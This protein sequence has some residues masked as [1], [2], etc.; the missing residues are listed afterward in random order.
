VSIPLPW[1]E[2]TAAWLQRAAPAIALTVHNAACL[3][4][5]EG[6][7]V[8]GN[9]GRALLTELLQALDAALGR[10]SWEGVTHPAL[11]A[12]T[13]GSDARAIGGA[14]LP[15]YAAYAPDSDLFLKIAS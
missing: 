2:A 3:L 12:G 8:D 9:I 13:I 15:L 5:M 6:V 14:L 1:R 10:H 7:I 11:L 4:D